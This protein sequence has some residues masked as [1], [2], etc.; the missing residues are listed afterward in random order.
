M[1]RRS[2]QIEKQVSQYQRKRKCSYDI[3]LSKIAPYRTNQLGKV[4][5]KKKGNQK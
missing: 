2:L 5:V 1:S 4:L 3:A